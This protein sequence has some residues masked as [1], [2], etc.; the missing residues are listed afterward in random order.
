MMRSLAGHGQLLWLGMALALAACVGPQG[1]APGG[2]AE[3]LA[4]T[5]WRLE[6]LNGRPPVTSQ[7]VPVP[8]LMFAADGQRAS[9]NA[10]CNQFNGAYT[11]DGASLRFGPLASTRRACAD[12]AGNAQETA[13]LRAL[14]STTRF[15]ATAERLVL[16]AGD[17]VVARLVRSE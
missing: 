11:Q 13:Y 17:Q 5:G 4:G 10:G 12:E 8:T 15:S 14:E 7:N 16:Y 3:P 6:E 2:T 9:G 1:A